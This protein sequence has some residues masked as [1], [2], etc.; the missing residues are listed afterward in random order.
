MLIDAKTTSGS[1]HAL[2]QA[3]RLVKWLDGGILV[4]QHWHGHGQRLESLKI[5]LE[6][7]IGGLNDAMRHNN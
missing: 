2:S 1:Q 6:G 3:K 4:I 7:G 5:V